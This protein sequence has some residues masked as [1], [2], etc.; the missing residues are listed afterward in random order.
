MGI[1]D[2]L[3]KQKASGTGGNYLP[4][5]IHQGIINEVKIFESAINGEGFGMS[6]KI[7]DSDSEEVK[8]GQNYDVSYMA[9]FVAAM[10]DFKRALMDITDCTEDEASDPASVK[11]IMAALAGV[12]VNIRA[13][14]K[15]TKAG[16]EVTKFYFTPAD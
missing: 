1:F 14:S 10:G 6:I 13:V 3:K 2:T 5:G 4:V 8:I 15:T 11:E 7:T 12:K 16:K 9:K